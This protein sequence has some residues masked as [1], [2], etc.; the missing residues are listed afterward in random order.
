[1][2][3]VSERLHHTDHTNTSRGASTTGI[4]ICP[5]TR[6]TVSSTTHTS[7]EASTRDAR[8]SSGTPTSRHGASNA[9]AIGR[10]PCVPPHVPQRHTRPPPAHHAPRAS[11]R[12]PRARTTG[13]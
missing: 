5:R 7:S 11:P 1:E 12:Q 2:K 8:S 3:L 13:G 10:S 4:S 6:N 9:Y